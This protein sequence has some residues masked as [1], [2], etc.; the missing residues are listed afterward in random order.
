MTGCCAPKYSG[1]RAFLDVVAAW[2]DCEEGTTWSRPGRLLP[3]HRLAQNSLRFT[4]SPPNYLVSPSFL[5][6]ISH[7]HPKQYC[8]AVP[9]LSSERSS[10]PIENFRGMPMSNRPRRKNSAI[11]RNGAFFWKVFPSP[12]VCLYFPLQNA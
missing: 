12:S 9:S 7:N 3:H 11:Q 8:L 4:I 10:R 5:T 2:A 1:Q 6:A